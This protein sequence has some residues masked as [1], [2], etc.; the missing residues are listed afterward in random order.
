MGITRE[1]SETMAFGAVM[2]PSER[3][4]ARIL[5][6]SGDGI[7]ETDSEGLCT[8]INPAA[9]QILGYGRDELIG[10]SLHDALHHHHADGRL[11]PLHDCPIFQAARTGAARRVDDEVFWHKLGHAVN[12]SYSVFP[13]AASED[14]QGAVIT[15]TDSSERKRKENDLR[16]LA[17]E[18]SEADRRKTE[19]IATLAHELRNPLAPVRSG[20]QVIAR[21]GDDKAA[22]T[23][24]RLM[25]ERQLGQM[26]RLINDLLDVARVTSG[27]M[28]L[29][30]QPIELKTI[31]LA[32]LEA[33]QP[34]MT[35]ATHN[36]T[37]EMPD[38]PVRLNADATR[39][40][41]AFTN[42]LS[43][44]AKY[45]PVRGQ[46]SV[47]VG[48]VGQSAEVSIADSGIGL[49]KESLSKIFEMFTR[50][51]ASA[52]GK[53]EG[54]GIGLNLVRRIVELHGGHVAARSPGPGHGSVFIVTLP[55]AYGAVV[56]TGATT[57]S[58]QAACRMRIMIVD[59]NV[60][61]AQTLSMLLMS[62]NHIT[63]V[64]H[65]GKD[66]LEALVTFKPEIIF[67]DIGMPE[68]NGYEVAQAIRA[69]PA[70]GNPILVALT[71]WGG[72]ADRERTARA[73]FNAHLTKPADIAVIEELLTAVR[74]Q[75]DPATEADNGH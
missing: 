31:L 32:A 42:L 55:L 17:S 35:A 25:M 26:V 34:Q 69:T 9:A 58:P 14:S 13:H 30:L 16:R 15:F 43:N 56:K 22:V 73:G 24:V 8:F 67:L 7:C 65:S 41:Q 39:L 53:K 28:S 20:L 18:L 33:T 49:R 54:L 1:I 50:V 10:R 75:T 12:V 2:R 64:A 71:G 38:V 59:D 3:Q 62:D 44:A 40:T 5:E 48:V 74:P 52:S 4:C 23:R 66:A 68:M 27:K 61:A 70:A 19:F 51:G 60:D 11:Y 6:S 45:T 46:I 37:V 29:Q 47:H 21:A 36:V 57:P 63:H 72:A